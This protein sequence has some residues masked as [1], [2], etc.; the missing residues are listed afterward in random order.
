MGAKPRDTLNNDPKKTDSDKNGTDDGQHVKKSNCACN[1]CIILIAK[2]LPQKLELNVSL[3]EKF[4]NRVKKLKI[5]NET[6]LR[7]HPK[8][9]YCKTHIQMMINLEPKTRLQSNHQTLKEREGTI[10]QQN[11]IEVRHNYIKNT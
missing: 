1:T 9:C 3:T 11:K 8:P 7:E 5:F 4:I 10:S 6:S 2:L